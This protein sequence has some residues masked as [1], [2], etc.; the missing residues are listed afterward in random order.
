MC[1]DYSGPGNEF[2]T[3]L[4]RLG[5]VCGD[6]PLIVTS[7]AVDTSTIYITSKWMSR[8]PWLDVY[9]IMS[10]QRNPFGC[11]SV[12]INVSKTS[13]LSVWGRMRSFQDDAYKHPWSHRFIVLQLVYRCLYGFHGWWKYCVCFDGDIFVLIIGA[14][15][16]HFYSTNCRRHGRRMSHDY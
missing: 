14:L 9:W 6:R 8:I 4:F 15:V 3:M 7:V 5:L 12:R 13:E 11:R 10:C 1:S 16:Q 2:C